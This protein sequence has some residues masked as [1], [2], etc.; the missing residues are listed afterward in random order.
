MIQLTHLHG[1]RIMGKWAPR[2]TSLHRGPQ[3][4]VA[5]FSHT[6][7]VISRFVFQ[8]FVSFCGCCVSTSWHM[9]WSRSFCISEVIQS[10]G[11]GC[12]LKQKLN[13]YKENMNDW[14]WFT[15]KH[16][17]VVQTYL[18]T[19]NAKF[20]LEEKS[21]STTDNSPQQNALHCSNLQHQSN[22]HPCLRVW[23]SRT[24]RVGAESHRR[25]GEVILLSW[26]PFLCGPQGSE[27]VHLSSHKDRRDL[28]KRVIAHPIE[29]VF[30]C[31]K[32]MSCY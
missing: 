19:T 27:F 30:V 14:T 21:E 29:E 5:T 18:T 16:P 2:L 22:M 26:D 7:L 10:R 17:T 1:S 28:N 31:F 24:R 8:S 4:Y 20:M 12:S 13:K 32:A 25:G 6:V 15:I 9:G 11:W 3:N 23:V